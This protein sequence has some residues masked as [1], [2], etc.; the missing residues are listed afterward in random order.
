M[1]INTNGG[2]LIDSPTGTQSD[3]DFQKQLALLKQL[4]AQADTE[5]ANAAAAKT[6]ARLLDPV[7][8]AQAADEVARF[9]GR[10]DVQLPNLT[11]PAPFTPSNFQPVASHGGALPTIPA[12]NIQRTALGSPTLPPMQNTQFG[13]SQPPPRAIAR[14]GTSDTTMNA[15]GAAEDLADPNH[16]AELAQ[17]TERANLDP[18]V[19][20]AKVKA[21]AGADKLVKVEHKDPMTGRTV[22]E[23]LPQSQVKGQT[24]EKGTNATTENRLASAQAVNQTG[25]DMLQKLSDPTKD[26]SGKTYA[27]K[28]GPVLG[29]FNT[30]R[31]F[32][33][34]PPPE[35]AELAGEIESYS[36]A[37]MGVHGMRSAQGAQ[38]IA[39]LMDQKHTPESLIATIRGLSQFSNHF[40]Q[41]EGRPAVPATAP[42]TGNIKSITPV[43]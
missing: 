20:A 15:K 2:I 25:E 13:Q 30:L 4:Q 33:G 7:Q 14:I 12:R 6:K 27:D 28:V 8:A 41:N 37:N 23:W 26:V 38:Q 42:R 11:S 35:F 39:K 43:P 9:Q 19:V 34:N 3:F 5:T 16:A 29:R 40:M 32:L 1:P 22:I 17:A 18:A 21:D 31:D 36:L 10:K 24:F